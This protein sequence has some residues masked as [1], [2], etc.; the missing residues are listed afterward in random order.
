MCDSGKPIVNPCILSRNVINPSLQC[1][2]SST[3]PTV[4]RARAAHA[5][6]VEHVSR[7]RLKMAAAFMSLFNS[8]VLIDGDYS[9]TRCIDYRP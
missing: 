7:T 6:F 9:V 8:A 5:L 1:D 2:S 3:V 4:L